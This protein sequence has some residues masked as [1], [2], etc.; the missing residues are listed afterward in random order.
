MKIIA[1]VAALF[2][3]CSICEATV[4]SPPV[5]DSAVNDAAIDDIAVDKSPTDVPVDHSDVADDDDDSAS[6]DHSEVD[7]ESEV[8]VDSKVDTDSTADDDSAADDVSVDD[9]AATVDGSDFVKS[10][11]C[12]KAKSCTYEYT[13]S[14]KIKGGEKVDITANVDIFCQ[15]VGVFK[16]Q[17]SIR[18]CINV[19][20]TVVRTTNEKK[21]Y[22]AEDVVP[23]KQ[24]G[25]WFCFVQSSTTGKIRDVFHDKRDSEWVV[26]FK[27]NIAS[28]FQANYKGSAVT[29]ETDSQS[30]HKS[31]YKYYSEGNKQIQERRIDRRD[32]STFAGKAESTDSK[33]SLYFHEKDKLELDNKKRIRFSKGKAVLEL[34]PDPE[35]KA[36]TASKKNDNDKGIPALGAI[37]K[38]KLKLSSCT[39]QTNKKEVAEVTVA[40]ASPESM[41]DGLLASMDED[42]ANEEEMEDLADDLPSFDETVKRV[43]R[44]V[45]SEEA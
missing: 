21:K 38:Y 30:N 40:L 36:S 17:K 31:H 43:Q 24:L 27:K 10:S 15:S 19:R 14:T 2:L 26:N 22:D 11:S 39:A 33:S 7:D 34:G 3:I 35:E 44:D 9:D 32:I 37:S 13:V 20:D 4:D 45:E 28:A 42:K 41:S 5:D 16:K 18:H 1:L 25:R 23:V 6:D 12:K 29:N 8:D